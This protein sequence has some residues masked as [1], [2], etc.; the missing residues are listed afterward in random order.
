MWDSFISSLRSRSNEELMEFINEF[1]TEGWEF[2]TYS[3]TIM[4][5]F[6]KMNWVIAIK[7]P[8]SSDKI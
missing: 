3:D 7:K 8:Y 5:P 1:D 2:E 6:E 4:Y